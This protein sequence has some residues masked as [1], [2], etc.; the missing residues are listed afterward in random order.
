MLK[1]QCPKL[2]S[3]TMKIL[4]LLILLVTICA[5]QQE[6]LKLA[7]KNKT[8]AAEAFTIVASGDFD[9]F[10]EVISQSYI[11]HC[12]AT[13]GLTIRSLG[14]FKEFIR[15]D[16]QVIPDQELEILHLVAEGDLV[17]FYGIYK[18]TQS[19][20]MGN[21]PPSGKFASLDFAGVHRIENDKIVETWITWDNMSMLS[22]LGH[23]SL[24][25]PE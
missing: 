22:Q 18:G 21:F 3:T 19:G 23:F 24:T 6:Q 8:I 17:G 2:D 4:N 16:R 15:Q 25:K 10:D 20:E 13:P 11:R 9:R 7:E 14:D 12:Q 5:C 1:S